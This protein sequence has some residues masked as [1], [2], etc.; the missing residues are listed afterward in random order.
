MNVELI[1]HC[2][3]DL[4]TV[5]AARV[6]FANHHEEFQEKGD[7][8]LINYLAK[9]GHWT[10]FSH[11]FVTFRIKAPIFVARQLFKHKV[12]LTEN[13]IS[14]RYVDKEPEFYIPK[15]WRGKA[16]N[17]K[18]GSTGIKSDPIFSHW[19]FNDVYNE[20]CNVTIYDI[21]DVCYEAYTTMLNKGVCPEQAR[22]VLPQAMYTEWYW[23]GSMVAFNRICNLRIS[24]DAQQESREIAEMIDKE[25]TTLWPVS[26]SALKNAR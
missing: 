12:G 2:G 18:Q 11:C 14:R 9:H 25:C 8:G 16:E 13:E 10:P 4:T 26:W 22:M 1:D 3:T 15:Q 5:N 20:Q 23:S 17:K 19:L 7:T 24:D 6:S 21:Y